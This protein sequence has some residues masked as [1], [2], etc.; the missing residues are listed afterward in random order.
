MRKCRVSARSFETLLSGSM[1]S[2]K[3]IAPAMQELTQAGVTSG[4]T[5]G[6]CPVTAAASIRYLQN[7]HLVATDRRPGSKRATSEAIGSP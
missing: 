2:P 7:V 4:S 3:W 5:P 6:V 1:M